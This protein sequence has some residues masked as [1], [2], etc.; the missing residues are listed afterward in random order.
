LPGFGKHRR[1]I[2]DFIIEKIDQ[3]D[4]N[5]SFDHGIG[6]CHNPLQH[7]FGCAQTSC[8]KRLTG[9]FVCR[10]SLVNIAVML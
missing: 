10:A 7:G 1:H 6:R 4:Q 2:G 3:K 5:N 9:I 8:T